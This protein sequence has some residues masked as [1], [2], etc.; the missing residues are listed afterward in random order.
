VPWRFSLK[1]L[2]W[3]MTGIFGALFIPILLD[4]LWH[5]VFCIGSRNDSERSELLTQYADAS[6]G[7]PLT[8]GIY[9]R[10][11]LVLVCLA[12]FMCAV[13][14][15]ITS[16]NQ[17]WKRK[18]DCFYLQY[19]TCETDWN[20]GLGD[21]NSLRMDHWACGNGMAGE[22]PY[23]MIG[24]AGL[25]CC[26]KRHMNGRPNDCLADCPR[27]SVL[28]SDIRTIKGHPSLSPTKFSLP[29]NN[30]YFTAQLTRSNLTLMVYNGSSAT[31]Q[32]VRHCFDFEQQNFSASGCRTA[33]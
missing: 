28:L 26:L 15:P 21:C 8:G 13:V 4:W 18:A 6:R 7:G 11:A 17:A 10:R 25:R 9:M 20:T 23:V 33:R 19:D 29:Q 2:G 31:A 24:C 14:L 5:N 22:Q 27:V 1:I 30:A 12:A 3:S 32:Q 16:S